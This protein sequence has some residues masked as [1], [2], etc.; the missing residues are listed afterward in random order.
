MKTLVVYYSKSGNTRRVA[1]E[2]ARALGGDTDELTE[3]GVK[4][5]GLFG[6]VFAGRDGMRGRASKIETP[7]KRPADYDILFIGSPVWGGNIVPAV[8][9]YMT[10]VDLAGKPVAVFCTA[11]GSGMEKTL[12]TMHSLTRTAKVLGELAVRQAELKSPETLTKRVAAWA[13][14]MA[15]ATK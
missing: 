5:S 2:I 4:R 9:S 3:V 14:E 8:R 10:T 11:G 7:K 12:V 1:E 13:H 15:A 6:F